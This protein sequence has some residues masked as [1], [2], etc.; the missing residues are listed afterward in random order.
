[1]VGV[2]HSGADLTVLKGLVMYTTLLALKFAADLEALTD[3]D[4]AAY[5]VEGGVETTRNIHFAQGASATDFRHSPTGTILVCG[6]AK[7]L[8]VLGRL[9][10]DAAIRRTCRN[11][12]ASSPFH[13]SSR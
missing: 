11:K 8:S 9:L 1:M 3:T 12:P 13:F 7:G 5:A 4:L 10:F 2:L 6:E